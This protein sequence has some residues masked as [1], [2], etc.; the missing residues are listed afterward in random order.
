MGFYDRLL[1]EYKQLDERINKLESF[2]ET[3]KVD[4]EQKAILSQQLF[5]MKGY[6]KILQ[7][8]IETLSK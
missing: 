6:H 4:D 5:W 2:L 3:D 7:Y 8:R 1:A